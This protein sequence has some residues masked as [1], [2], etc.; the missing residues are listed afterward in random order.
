MA[1][2]E[3]TLTADLTTR[4]DALDAAAVAL[5]APDAA[6]LLEWLGNTNIRVGQTNFADSSANGTAAA[7]AGWCRRSNRFLY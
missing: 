4:L 1:T 2:R 3:E 7:L 6:T 5:G